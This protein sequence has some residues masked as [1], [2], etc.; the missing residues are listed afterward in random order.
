MQIFPSVVKFVTIH[1][2]LPLRHKSI[3]KKKKHRKANM[4]IFLYGPPTQSIGKNIFTLY[5][6]LHKVAS[7]E[8]AQRCNLLVY[9]LGMELSS[10]QTLLVLEISLHSTQDI[11]KFLPWCALQSNT[12]QFELRIINSKYKVKAKQHVFFNTFQ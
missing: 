6:D 8:C 1:P 10:P 7:E 3:L 5:L 9:I 4:H 12:V 2:I 11:L